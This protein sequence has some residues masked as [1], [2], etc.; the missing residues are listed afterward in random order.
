MIYPFEADLS[1]AEALEQLR[2][3]FH[4]TR[5]TR[6]VPVPAEIVATI[7]GYNNGKRE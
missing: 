3:I 2:A 4:K 7:L 5:L 6:D 1:Q